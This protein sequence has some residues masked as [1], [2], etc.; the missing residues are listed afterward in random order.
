[1]QSLV[2]Y[3]RSLSTMHAVF[4]YIRPDITLR[5]GEVGNGLKRIPNSAPDNVRAMGRLIK[6]TQIDLSGIAEIHMVR[7]AQ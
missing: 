2:V 7:N 1:M 5:E 6:I 3:A 4:Q